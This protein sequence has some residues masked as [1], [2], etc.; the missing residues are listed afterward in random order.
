MAIK[1]LTLLCLIGQGMD[2]LQKATHFN[3]RFLFKIQLYKFKDRD[4]SDK[5]G[6]NHRLQENK[7]KEQP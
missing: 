3:L 6:Q 1:T 2:L 4:Y 7:N 5:F